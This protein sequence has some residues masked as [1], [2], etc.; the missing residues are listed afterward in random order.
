MEVSVPILVLS[1]RRPGEKTPTYILR[2]VFFPAPET[3][4]YNLGRGTAK[5]AASLRKLL[6]QLAEAGKH[7][8]F[9]QYIY[10][11]PLEGQRLKLTLELKRSTE[12][13][14]FYAVSLRALDRQIACFPMLPGVWFEIPKDGNESLHDRATAVLTEYFRKLEREEET[15]APILRRASLDGKAWLTT[16]EF[17]VE[18]APDLKKASSLLFAALFAGESMDGATELDN[19]GR[20]LDLLY[21]DDLARSLCREQ[22]AEELTRLLAARDRRPVLVLGPRTVGKT[23]LVHEAVY[24]KVQQQTSRFRNRRHTWLLSPQRLISGMSYVGQWENRL[25]AI[26]KECRKKDHIL[27][28]DDLVGLFRA[29]VSRDSDLA[30]AHVLKPILEQRQVRIVGEATPA[31]FRV[32][33]ELDRGFADLFHVISLQEPDQ[34]TSLRVLLSVIRQLERRS[35]CQFDLEV[36]PTVMDLARRFSRERAFP[37]QPA[38]MLTRLASRHPGT[39]I[40]RQIVLKDFESQ[41]G[42][43]IAFLDPAERLRREDILA[44]I[45]QM[46]VGQKPALEAAAD[47][48]SIAKARINDPERPWGTFLFL[49]PTGVG[50]T[51]CAKAI[52]NYLL[53]SP[54]RMIRFDMNEFLSPGDVSRLVGTLDQP[55]GLLTSAIRRQP[56]SV[57][58]LDEIEKAH[59]A[60][61]D[62]LLQ[63]LGE[64]RLT[65]ALGRTA[66]F[67]NAVLILTSN[68]GSQQAE[69]S[70]GFQPSEMSKHQIYVAAAERFFRPEFLNRLDFLIPFDRLTKPEIREISRQAVE[71]LGEREGFVRRKCIL[72]PDDSVLDYVIA[73]GFDPRWGARGV[74]RMIEKDL[75]R[76]VA[77]ALAKTPPAG[78]TVVSLWACDDSIQVDA[79]TLTEIDPLPR[80]RGQ[81]SPDASEPTLERI[82]ALLKRLLETCQAHRPSGPMT[83]GNI[84]PEQFH[85]LAMVEAINH[86]ETRCQ[87]L[88]EHLGAGAIHN[89]LSADRALRGDSNLRPAGGAD[90]CL[91]KLGHAEASHHARNADRRRRPRL[92]PR[93]FQRLGDSMIPPTRWSRSSRNWHC[94]TS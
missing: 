60:V 25:L 24:R 12:K 9:S 2:P 42:L 22:E 1:T 31:G 93:S 72:H 41:S 77:A 86:L 59:P 19:T 45:E 3:R 16:V 17:D 46:M 13:P 44:G 68:L 79:S 75:I 15:V 63:V 80:C 85:Y 92:S 66:D 61:F 54:D 6:K 28:F 64:G 39:T 71:A 58:L 14:V 26:L 74:R 34:E 36:L 33:R 50:K 81:F 88:K 35:R 90:A 18:T 51:Q 52:A 30:V 67:R 49:G 10:A 70:V 73:R 94:S 43:K 8:R 40:T 5:L 89:R 23:A 4:D 11:P 83:S 69:N 29:G 47:V 84:R 53:G 56:Y 76:P 37:G 32:L 78:P 91:A 20:D 38:L 82:R 57:V 48:I 7:E 27:Y 62:L 55:E 65:D 21:P 87:E